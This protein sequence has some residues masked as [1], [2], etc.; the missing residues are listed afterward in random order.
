MCCRRRR[1][2]GP[3]STGSRQCAAAAGTGHVQLQ[4]VRD[5]AVRPDPVRLGMLLGWL[6]PGRQG[7]PMGRRHPAPQLLLRWESAFGKSSLMVY[8]VGWSGQR[9]VGRRQSGHGSNSSETTDQLP[10]GRGVPDLHC[11]TCEW[12]WDI[13][14]SGGAAIRADCGPAGPCRAMQPHTGVAPGLALS[15]AS[16]MHTI[17]LTALGAGLLAARAIGAA[18]SLPARSARASQGLQSRRSAKHE[19][20]HGRRVGQSRQRQGSASR[21]AACPS[22]KRAGHLRTKWWLGSKLAPATAKLRTRRIEPEGRR[23]AMKGQSTQSVL[24]TVRSVH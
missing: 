4:A 15:M 2:D 16:E 11:S 20:C 1:Q 6:R 3:P 12:Q 13:F 22:S 8:R 7:G 5:S 21:Q 18:P 19:R 17:P 10:P 9:L 24:R 23:K 14:A